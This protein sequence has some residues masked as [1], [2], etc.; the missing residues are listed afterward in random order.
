MA[1]YNVWSRPFIQRSSALGFLTVGMGAGRRGADSGGI[2]D[3]QRRGL[4]QLRCP[5]MDCRRLSRHRRRRAR[6]HPVGHGAG[7]RDADPR[8][9]HHDRQPD[10][11]GIARH[12]SSASRS[13]PISCW[14]WS[15]C[16]PEYGSPPAIQKP[17]ERVVR[18]PACDSCCRDRLGRG[19]DMNRKGGFAA[20]LLSAMVAVGPGHAQSGNPRRKLQPR[21]GPAR[22]PEAS[23]AYYE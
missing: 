12:S 3:R 10:R 4:A 7:A 23:P 22:Q 13:P 1:F 11:G 20:A 5:A 9:L 19:N 6:L 2:A 18:S 15:R 8:R 16:L 17:P 14:V 21:Q